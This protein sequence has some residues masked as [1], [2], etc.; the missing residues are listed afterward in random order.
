MRL[1]LLVLVTA[2]PT[3]IFGF[4]FSRYAKALY[5]AIDHY[6]DPHVK[7]PRGRPPVP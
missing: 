3:V 6:F 7:G 5:L 2:V 4:V 1:W